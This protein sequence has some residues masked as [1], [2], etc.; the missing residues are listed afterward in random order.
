MARRVYW[1]ACAFLGLI[2]K[3]VDKH[4]DCMAVWREAERKKTVIFT[5][6]FTWAEVYKAKCEGQAKPLSEEGDKEIEVVLSQP[7]IEAV[8]VDEGI[9]L[10]ARRLMRHHQE[11][12]K[13]TDAVHLATALR[14]SVDEMHTYDGS[15]LLKL[16]SRVMCADGRLLKIC[17]PAPAPPEEPE[18]PPAPLLE[19]LEKGES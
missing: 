8:V 11:C 5:S 1:D 3:E 12:K 6:F 13:P 14:L 9:G 18:L 7:F 10:S 4:P 15:D 2:N 19:R 17:V 16:N